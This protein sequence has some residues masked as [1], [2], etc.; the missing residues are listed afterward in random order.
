MRRCH[1]CRRQ[2]RQAEASFALDAFRGRERLQ[3]STRPVLGEERGT[4][5]DDPN[6]D[7]RRPSLILSTRRS[8]TRNSHSSY[9]TVTPRSLRAW[10]N[11]RTERSL[12]S[13]ACEMNRSWELSLTRPASLRR[14]E[15]LR[16]DGL[17]A[18]SPSKLTLRDQKA[19]QRS[20][21]TLARSCRREG[22]RL[23]SSER[24]LAA[25]AQ[26]LNPGLAGRDGPCMTV[27]IPA[28]A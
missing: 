19:H 12:S 4:Q 23:L 8:P 20:H 10:A 9:Q 5:H 7:R 3:F 25:R 22:V 1:R 16:R 15:A 17:S 14:A 27:E 2:A 18:S 24:Y 28:F 26:R 13:L 21:S 6:L 11:G